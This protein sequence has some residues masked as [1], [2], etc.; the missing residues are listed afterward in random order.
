MT[1]RKTDVIVEQCSAISV[2]FFYLGNCQLGK[3]FQGDCSDASSQD[4]GESSSLKKN[5]P[6]KTSLMAPRQELSNDK[7]A[8]R[9]R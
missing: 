2:L 3:N 5:K 6:K 1:V 7:N 9:S 4:E 8:L